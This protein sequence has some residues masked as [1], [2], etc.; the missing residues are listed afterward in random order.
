M[1][2]D[3]TP[4]PIVVTNEQVELVKRTVAQNATPAESILIGR[5]VHS[6]VG[7]GQWGGLAKCIRMTGMTPLPR[8]KRPTPR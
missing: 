4:A 8:K 3:I 1:T 7:H 2:Q 5:R 6:R